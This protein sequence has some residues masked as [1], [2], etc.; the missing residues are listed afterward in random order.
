VWDADDL[1][2]KMDTI[3]STAE[4]YLTNEP[5]ARQE[6]IDEV[7]SFITDHKERILDEIKDGLPEWNRSINP[8]LCASEDQTVAG[9][10]TTQKNTL[11]LLPTDIGEGE[12]TITVQEES[13]PLM[14]V[15]GNMGM[16]SDGFGGNLVMMQWILGPVD[17]AHVFLLYIVL[18]EELFVEGKTIQM[19]YG[20]AEVDVALV[21]IETFDFNPYGF[22]M[23]GEMTIEKIDDVDDGEVVISFNAPIGRIVI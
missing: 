17:E 21:D 4:P 7:K 14:M 5:V 22:V 15:R 1:L 9:V 23:T 18:P 6:E 19:N 13:I 12:A 11:S 16:V 2:E 8:V 10:L 3:Q 20:E